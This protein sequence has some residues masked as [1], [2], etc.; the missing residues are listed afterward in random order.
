M[1]LYFISP[2][3]YITSMITPKEINE[4][5]EILS[6]AHQDFQKSLTSHAFFKLSNRTVGEDLVQETFK[7][8]F[9]FVSKTS[10]IFSPMASING[11][12][13]ELPNC[14]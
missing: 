2:V 4:K 14:L 6:K 5:Q 7:I 1:S 11:T 10:T 13:T 9:L 12:T 3:I 8:H